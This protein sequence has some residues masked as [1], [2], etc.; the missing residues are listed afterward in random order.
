MAAYISPR[1]GAT[2]IRD[3]PRGGTHV[4]ISSSGPSIS[5]PVSD[6]P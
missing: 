1:P 2:H 3:D 5:A 6:L 4:T